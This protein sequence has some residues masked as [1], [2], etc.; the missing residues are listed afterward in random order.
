[1]E[2][3]LDFKTKYNEKMTAS[4][5][6]SDFDKVLI[7]GEAD[8]GKTAFFE[9]FCE[10]YAKK[11]TKIAEDGK[12][13]VSFLPSEPVFFNKKNVLFNL[14]Y[15]LKVLK[16][17][18]E[19]VIDELLSKFNFNRLKTKLIKDLTYVEKQ[20]LALI[21]ALIKEPEIILIDDLFTNVSNN[22][23]EISQIVKMALEQKCL[24]FVAT[25]DRIP[26]GLKF[27]KIFKIDEQGFTEISSYE[28]YF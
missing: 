9:R 5:N 21:R 14:K 19:K 3:C 20:K 12:F 1:M 13:K 25:R 28:N 24:V 15:A 27:D 4:I 8:S 23:D 7:I 16:I 10:K 2:F 11:S 17:K 18:D 6:L 26:I 22:L